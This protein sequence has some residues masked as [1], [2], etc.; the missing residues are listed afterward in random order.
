MNQISFEAIIETLQ[1]IALLRHRIFLTYERAIFRTPSG[2]HAHKQ[3]KTGQDRTGQD[4]IGSRRVGNSY[5]NEHYT[6][7]MRLELLHQYTECDSF[8][9]IGYDHQHSA[10]GTFCSFRCEY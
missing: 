4:R 1:Y 7:R 5:N 2:P 6:A 10:L 8:S 9:I 3:D